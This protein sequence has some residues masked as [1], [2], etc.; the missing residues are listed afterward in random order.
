MSL[1]PS[2]WGN[3]SE[4]GGHSPVQVSA[5]QAGSGSTV[6]ALVGEVRTG[7]MVVGAVSV[8]VAGV[9]VWTTHGAMSPLSGAAVGLGSGQS[10]LMGGVLVFAGMAPVGLVTTSPG[11]GST[12]RAHTRRTPENQPKCMCPPKRELSGRKK[13]SAAR[14]CPD[15]DTDLSQVAKIVRIPAHTYKKIPQNSE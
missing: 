7:L 8:S 2:K 9:C 3:K 15:C 4:D 5:T 10:G 14:N 13:I 12:G 6:I 11:S 1:L